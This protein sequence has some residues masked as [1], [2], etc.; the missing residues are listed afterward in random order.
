[1]RFRYANLKTGGLDAVVAT[2]N[3]LQN[4]PFLI[5]N[6]KNVSGG[7]DIYNSISKKARSGT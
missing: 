4:A 2:L 1:M 7:G 3:M 6:L 5:Y